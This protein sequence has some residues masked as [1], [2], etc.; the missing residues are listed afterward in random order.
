[1]SFEK[2]N[3]RCFKLHPINFSCLGFDRQIIDSFHIAAV[4]GD[5]RTV[6]RLLQDGV[7]VDVSN[8]SGYTAL[9]RAAREN[10]TDVAERLLQAGADA[11]KQNI[12]GDTPM[13]LAALFNSPEVARLLANQGAD[14]TL[15]NSDNKTPLDCAHDD[16]I[17]RLLLEIQ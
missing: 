11:N 12:N 16:E 4:R 17:R 8:V 13:H 9:H 6:N 14:Y 5:F 10:Q 2:I 3:L 7:S 15:K 1:M